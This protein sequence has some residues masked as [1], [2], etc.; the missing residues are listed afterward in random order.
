MDL[1]RAI[2]S[3]GGFPENQGSARG[4][5]R[6]RWMDMARNLEPAHDDRHVVAE[7]ARVAAA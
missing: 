6:R 2:A 1:Q 7:L 4:A 5:A 3:L